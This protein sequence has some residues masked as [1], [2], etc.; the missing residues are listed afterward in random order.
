MNIENGGS[1]MINYLKDLFSLSKRFNIV[2]EDILFID[3][4]ISGINVD[5]NTDRIRFYVKLLFGHQ[6]KYFCALQV[7]KDSK[8]HIKN[9]ILYFENECIGE[10]SKFEIDFCDTYYMRRN[11]TVLNIKPVLQIQ[12]GKLDAYRGRS[13]WSRDHEG[14]FDRLKIDLQ[15]LFLGFPHGFSVFDC[16]NNVYVSYFIFGNLQRVFV[17]YYQVRPLA[18]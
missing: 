18:F 15:K 16:F 2:T 1:T 7:R 13:A 4:N 3:I 12:G 14:H 17:K 11:G 6:G 5:I 9:S 8:Y 10:V